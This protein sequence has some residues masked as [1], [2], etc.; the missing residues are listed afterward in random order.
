MLT[1]MLRTGPP[2][3]TLFL[4]LTTVRSVGQGTAAG[5][6][7]IAAR[8]R[9]ETG[10][11]RLTRISTAIPTAGASRL[12]REPVPLASSQAETP[13]ATRSPDAIRLEPPR[14]CS[15]RPTA[16]VVAASPVISAE[17]AGEAVVAVE[18]AVEDG[19]MTVETARPTE[20]GTVS[21]TIGT[22]RILEM[23]EAASETGATG[24][25]RISGAEDHLRREE[26][27]LRSAEISGMQ[28][29]CHWA[30]TRNAPGG[31]QGTVL[32]RQAPPRR[33]PR[34]V[35]RLFEAD[36]I[37]AGVEE[38]PGVAANGIAAVGGGAPITMIG[39]GILVQEVALKRAGGDV[40][41]TTAIAGT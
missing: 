30:S 1:A 29:T 15:I 18:D 33:I 40:T 12:N 41:W 34:S 3:M 19:G 14:H 10:R 7:A 17:E 13:S 4:M 32:C 38:G 37:A 26:V 22:G 27:D 6:K 39:I 36:C 21:R 24:D 23:R 28:E 16:R 5:T 9:R 8:V 25:G 31:D 35:P 11:R 20:D 2:V